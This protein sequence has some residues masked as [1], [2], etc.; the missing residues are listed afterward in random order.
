LGIADGGGFTE[1][2]DGDRHQFRIIVSPEDAAQ[3]EALKPFVRDLM[4]RMER[5]LDTELPIK[6]AMAS[7]PSPISCGQKVNKP[8]QP[9]TQG[10]TK[11]EKNDCK[12]ML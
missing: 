2:C 11:P 8:V 3:M 4:T 5:D 12:T 7:K 9:L 6:S 1:G 10:W